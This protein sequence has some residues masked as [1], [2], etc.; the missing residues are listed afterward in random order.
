MICLCAV[1][2]HRVR[3]DHG[4][5]EGAD[6]TAGAT[7]KGDKAAMDTGGGGHGLAGGGAIALGDGMVSGGELELD[8][9][10][11]VRGDGVGRKGEGVAAHEDGDKTGVCR[12]GIFGYC[13]D[14]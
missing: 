14:I 13:L 6:H 9:V 11:G 1:Q 10:A 12:D 4:H 7:V 3:I 2:E 8:H 5:N